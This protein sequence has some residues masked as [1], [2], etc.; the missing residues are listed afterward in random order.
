M[1]RIINKKR[2]DTETATL[3][4]KWHNGLP[5]SDFSA[6]RAE[7]YQTKSGS[8]FLYLDGGPL[9]ECR[10]QT[11]SNCWSGSP[12]IRSLTPEQAYQWLEEHNKDEALEKYFATIIQEA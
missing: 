2:Y 6:L 9:T 7:L 11:G 10:V 3:V 5:W 1:K 12:K 4:A 8:W